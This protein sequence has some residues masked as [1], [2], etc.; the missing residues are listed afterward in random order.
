MDSDDD[1]NIFLNKSYD[2]S[3]KSRK[4][5]YG[6][7]Q[8][9]I[10][11]T[12]KITNLIANKNINPEVLIEPSCGTG[13]FIITSLKQFSNLKKIYAVELFKP[14]IITA[15][16]KILELFLEN[17]TLIKPK[18]QFFHKNVFDFNFNS[19]VQENKDLS[20]L[21]IGNPP[22]VTN[23]K[24][25]AID[26]VNLPRKSN[27]NNQ[28]GLDALTG[29]SNFDIAEAIT[30]NIIQ[31][32]E[33]QSGTLA[34]LVKNNV[35]KNLLFNQ[36]QNK[37]K[38]VNIEKHNIDCKMEFNA[39]ADASLFFCNFNFNPEYLS[40]EFDLYSLNKINSFGWQN[41]KFVSNVE[42]YK[43]YKGIDGVSPFKWRQGLKHD[44]ASIMELEKTNGCYTNKL[45]HNIKL[46]EEL[47]YPFL[48]SSDLKQTVI[49][50][51]R[52]YVIITQKKIGQTTAYLK[53]EFPMIYDYL[54]K[55]L[56]H[57]DL[58]KSSIYNNNPPFSIFGIGD[59]SFKKF[60][61]AVSSLYKTYHFSLVMPIGNKPVMLDDTCYFIGFDTIEF[62][63]YSYIILNTDYAANFFKSITFRDSKRIF[64]KDILMR[65]D[66]YK[67][68]KLLPIA[69]IKSK[70][71]E[72]NR[73][74]N[75]NITLNTWNEFR[76]SM[77]NKLENQ[78]AMF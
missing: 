74:I 22:W 5:E 29:K 9:N 6:D 65:I 24:L 18:I 66:L 36:I 44:C 69:F 47:V 73:E 28:G 59:Y 1:I 71:E 76:A 23:S 21:I 60:K 61:V 14:Y 62:A 31:A 49:S 43:D 20:F 26:S 30:Q 4:I 72:V 42:L 3:D 25:G 37:F 68:S 35:I 40:S 78:M 17:E 50:N 77:E 34:F 19:I 32:F 38:I 39:A 15:K 11:L 2:I 67:I 57:F 45:N 54:N 33:N 64:T 55:N 12:S 10:Q 7:F 46:E 16:L 56:S 52:K 51:S 41:D 70:L 75:Q 63:V 48:K 13:N 8:T 27:I 58:R 53:T